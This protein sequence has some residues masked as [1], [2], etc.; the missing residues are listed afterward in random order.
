MLRVRH[1]RPRPYTPKTNGKAERFV[2]T[3]MRERAYALPYRSSET[4]AADLPRWLRHDNHERPHASLARQAPSAW[5]QP[6]AP[7][8]SSEVTTSHVRIADL[9]E[10]AEE[11]GHGHR[12]VQER[13]ADLAREDPAEAILSLRVCDPAMGSSHFLAAAVDFLADSTLEAVAAGE[14][15]VPW[16]KEYHYDSPLGQRI[17]A[18]R[19]RLRGH[20]RGH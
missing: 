9:F 1:I 13:L 14:E 3:L 19:E 4:R 8:T 16:A 17:E 5:L 7:T 12:P 11:L 15:A 20:A 2:Q 18:I 6:L 10:R